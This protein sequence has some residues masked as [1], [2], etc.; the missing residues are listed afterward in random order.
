MEER[1]KIVEI[2]REQMG[3]EGVVNA[4]AQNTRLCTCVRRQRSVQ[5]MGLQI[6]CSVFLDGH[7]TGVEGPE[8]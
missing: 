2:K 5:Q 3:R 4:L 6:G 8:K 7:N 1:Q